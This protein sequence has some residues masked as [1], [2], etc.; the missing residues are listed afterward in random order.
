MPKYLDRHPTTPIPPEAMEGFRAQ[1][2]NRQPDGVT[3]ISFVVG[4]EQSY[5]LSEADSPDQ[6][7]K[8]HEDMGVVLADGA[9]EEVTAT[10][11]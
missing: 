8:H 7:H 2:G 10:L 1:M 6:I 3:L 11:P 5:C 4:K 9:I